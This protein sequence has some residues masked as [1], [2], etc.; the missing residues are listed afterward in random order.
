M[1]QE[2]R[3]QPWLDSGT[4]ACLSF[5][6]MARRIEFLLG[7]L[8]ISVCMA[9]GGS[10]KDAES[11][12][13]E[14]GMATH[15]EEDDYDEVDQPAVPSDGSASKNADQEEEGKK[16]VP[17]PEFT[18][19]MSVN[20][21]MNA[22]PPGIERLNIDQEVLGRP[23]ADPKTYEPCKLKAQDHFKLKVAIWDGRAVGIDIESKNKKLAECIRQQIS[24]LKWR[25]KAKSL[26]TVEYE[27]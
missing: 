1:L 24:Q 20:D 18:E 15:E 8:G 6:A 21:A 22:V 16:P 5:L 2:I 4:R 12:T 10:G 7:V 14:Y 13:D 19:G 11:P 9:C 3:G 27:F 17:E 23:L 26:N 25:D